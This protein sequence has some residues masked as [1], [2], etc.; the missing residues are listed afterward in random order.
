MNKYLV[1]PYYG[2][3]CNSWD[4]FNNGCFIDEIEVTAPDEET[5]K[6]LALD[7]YLSDQTDVDRS[8]IEKNPSHM[9]DNT[10]YTETIHVDADGNGISKDDYDHDKGHGFLYQ[11]IDFN[12]VRESD[13]DQNSSI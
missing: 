7:Q 6:D 5:A 2:H 9:G 13:N 8:L 11:Y 12:E 3:D 4:G 1:R 10:L